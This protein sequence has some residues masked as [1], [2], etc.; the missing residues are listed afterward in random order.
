MHSSKIIGVSGA[1]WGITIIFF[2]CF[3]SNFQNIQ[4]IILKFFF[5]LENKIG[6]NIFFSKSMK[7]LL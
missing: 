6:E 3:S 1:G 7:M 4:K 2:R 5:F